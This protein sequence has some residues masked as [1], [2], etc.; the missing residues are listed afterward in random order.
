MS[1]VTYHQGMVVEPAALGDRPVRADA[2]R[3]VGS[4]M[5][6]A[7]RLLSADPAATMEEIATEAGVARTTVHRHFASRDVLVAS[8]TRAAWQ[9]IHDAV[10]Q[11]HPATAPPLVA[12]HQVTANVLR[13]KSGWP[14]AL[15]QPVN[16]PATV[17]L[18]D[19][20]FTACDHVLD[21]AQR[22][23]L[24]PGRA[25]LVWTRRVYLALIRET[26]HTPAADDAGQDANQDADH[27]A[28]RIIDTM[29]HGV[30]GPPPAER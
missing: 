3:S 4:I 10:E 26:M 28:A 15:G 5:A 1:N 30:A 18:Q 6:A 19:R 29:L 22:S 27:L 14:F 16:D 20:V 8:M 9:Q 7:E 2:R 24:V 11:A 13:I 17:Q 23:G 12:L 21:R 25:D